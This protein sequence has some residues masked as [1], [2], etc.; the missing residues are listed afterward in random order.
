MKSSEIKALIQLLDDD[1]QE[2][3]DHVHQK[4]L[5]I[6]ASV[7]PTLEEAWG[8]DG[9][10]LLQGRLEDIIHSIQFDD[11]LRVAEKW[12]AQGQ[13]DL[14]T[15][16]YLVSKYY[17]PDLQLEEVQKSVFR[18]KQRIWL[19]LNYNQTALE[20]IQI[21]NH[22]MYNVHRFNGTTQ[23]STEYQDFC[24]NHLL[25]SKK[26][27]AISLG[28]LYQI[29]ANDLHLPVYGV[30]LVRHYILCFTK[31]TIHDFDAEARLEREVM[32]YINPLNRGSIFSRNE[33]KEYLEK[34]KAETD[35]KYYEPASPVVIIVELLSNLR[36]VHLH[37]KEHDRVEDIDKMIRILSP[38]KGMD[39][40]N[41]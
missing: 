37:L 18:I 19:E 29:L 38:E 11:V 32:F 3:Y 36:D 28:I 31:K 15:G 40:D 5:S 8:V 39:S 35:H 41:Y 2:V 4:L 17:Y 1:D 12:M 24:I 23:A 14:L 26:G 20:Q 30:P 6:G 13:Q 16:A 27:N 10:E 25:E 9:N 34:L 21:F 22:M 33:I 7:I